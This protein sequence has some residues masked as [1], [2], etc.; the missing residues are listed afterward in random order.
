MNVHAARAAVSTVLALSLI[1]CSGQEASM[2]NDQNL[3]A[4]QFNQLMQRP[5]IE[6]AAA[7]YQEMD[8]KIRDALTATFPALEWQQDNQMGGAACGA[9]YPGLD[10]DGEVRGL[11]NWFATGNIPDSQW[12]KAISVV[13][14]VA[15]SYGF[16]VGQATVNR[17]HD[18]EIVFHD[19]YQAELNIGTAVNTTLLVRTGC[20]LTAEAKKRGTP[21]SKSSY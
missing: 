17:P 18:H 13:H 7:R 16:D 9:G 14:G 15:Q 1:G 10:S 2:N 3:T 21:L 6:Q 11:P 19:M 20:H 8:Q 5:D 4:Q 12:D